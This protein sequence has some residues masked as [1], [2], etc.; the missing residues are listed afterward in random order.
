MKK[1]LLLVLSLIAVFACL[2]AISASA[3]EIDGIYYTLSGSGENATAAVNNENATKCTLENV[4]IPETVTNEGVTYTVTNIA[5][6]A[7]RNNTYV[8][9]IETP[10]TLTS[11]GEHA[12]REMSSLTKITINASESFKKFSNAEF[13]NDSALTY[14]DLSGCKGLTG[15]G[16]GGTYDHTFFGCS[17][18]ETVVLPK[19]ITYIGG[20]AFRGCTSLSGT[21]DLSSYSITEIGSWAFN[22]CSKLEK[23]IFPSTLT[24]IGSNCIQGTKSLKSLVLP[25]GFN[26]L[27]NDAIAEITLDVVIFPTLNAENSIHNGSFHSVGVK[28]LIYEGTNYEVLNGEGKLFAGYTAKPFSEYVPGTTYS[29]IIFYGATLCSKCNGLY[30]SDTEQV[31]F[32]D[33]LSGFSKGKLCSHCAK[34]DATQESD[35]MFTF[36]GFSIPEN[37]DAG[38]VVK[39]TVN[40]EAIELYE[41]LT[42]K[43]VSYGLYAA[44]E[45][46]LEDGD[47]FDANGMPQNGA[48]KAEVTTGFMMLKLKVAG[49]ETDEQKAAGLALGVYVETTKDEEKEYT[50]LNQE[51][52]NEGEKYFFVSYNYVKNAISK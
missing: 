43:T 10:S 28:A 26:S 2:F 46:Q 1:R 3:V 23:I 48:V 17:K 18:L 25:D 42:G 33:Y 34:V 38:F 5:N 41:S 51:K 27:A 19:G 9:E 30:E 16:D 35:A 29:K 20:S 47:I 44:T 11:I 12:F 8:K 52:P 37:G 22:G 15:I 32:T 7:F 31:Y 14:V 6:S 45:E 49:F 39:Y 21:M 40:N 36:E 13:Y 50:F 24:S 4:V